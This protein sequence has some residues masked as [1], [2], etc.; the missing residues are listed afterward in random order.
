MSITLFVYFCCSFYVIGGRTY[1]K[2]QRFIIFLPT[3]N[4]ESQLWTA[5][6]TLPW[7]RT[8]KYPVGRVEF[9]F[10]QHGN[11]VI[12][13]GGLADA[14][15]FDYSVCLNDVWMFN[16]TTLQWYHQCLLQILCTKTLGVCMHWEKHTMLSDR[17]LLCT[18]RSSVGGRLRNDPGRRW[19][20]FCWTL[21]RKQ[22][23]V[24]MRVVCT[25]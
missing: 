16:V 12:V 21:W 1:K 3:F 23:S 13:A 2:T 6:K 14:R 8:G 7:P 4:F 19:P 18:C 17:M 10:L 11:D 22:G 9:G 24:V 20:T 15:D 5:T 25:D